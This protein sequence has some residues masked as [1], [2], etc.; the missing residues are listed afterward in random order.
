MCFISTCSRILAFESGS[1]LNVF[2]AM[3]IVLGPVMHKILSL[4]PTAIQMGMCKIPAPRLDLELALHFFSIIMAESGISYKAMTEI[5]QEIVKPHDIEGKY[6]P[7]FSSDFVV[8]EIWKDLFS[9]T[10][11]VNHCRV[12]S[13]NTHQLI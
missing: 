5:S 10:K 3:C 2:K 4:K 6:F 8:K 13:D 1:A 7:D 11:S 9:V 12:K